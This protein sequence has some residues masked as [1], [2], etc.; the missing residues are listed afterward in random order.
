MMNAINASTGSNVTDAF[1]FTLGREALT[2]EHEFNRQ[3]GFDVSDDD[4]PQF[5]YDEPLAPTGYTA[6]FKGSDVYSMYDGLD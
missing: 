4:L 6:R 1:F 3:A 5:F 2:M